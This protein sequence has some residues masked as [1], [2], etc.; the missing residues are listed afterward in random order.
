MLVSTQ[1]LLHIERCHAALPCGCD[2]LTVDFV[3][4]VSRRKNAKDIGEGASWLR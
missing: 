1:Q 4:H 3:L 2:G